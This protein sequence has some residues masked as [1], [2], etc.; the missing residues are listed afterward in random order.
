MAGQPMWAAVE[1]AGRLRDALGVALP[2]G[3]PE[4]FTEV[5]PDPL[6]DLVARWART[7]GP[8]AAADLA[9][10]Y[11]LG[12]AVVGM[13]LRR[14]AADGRVAE[15]EFL[16]SRHGTQWCD[17]GVLRMLRRRCLARLRK[18]AEPVP[19]A[20]LGRFLPAWHGIGS[21][22][23]GLGGRTRARCLRRSS[24]WPARRCPR[25][26]LRRSCCPDGCP[27]TPPRCSTSSTAAGEVVWAGAG[28]VGSGDGWLVLAP[29]ESAPLLLP[30][31]GELTMTPL[32]GAVLTALGGGGGMFFRM[33]SD[34]VAAVLDGHPADDGDLV[35]ALWDLAWAGLVTNDT[36]APLRVVTSGGAPARR[37]AAPRRATGSSLAADLGSLSR[38]RAWD[39]EACT[40]VASG[41]RFRSW[42][43]RGYGSGG[44]RGPAGRFPACSIPGLARGVAAGSPAAMPRPAVTGAGPGARPCPRGPGRPRCPAGGRCCRNGTGCQKRTAC[45]QRTAF[46]AALLAASIRERPPCGRTRSR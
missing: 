5:L 23:T 18:E 31:P 37:P 4:A 8:F 19:P 22:R 10:R 42:A 46:P 7:H 24:G 11:G 2:V 15:G 34:R 35:A 33:L 17:S 45:S 13:A 29:A 39:A 27:A 32:H 44:P 43:D 25:R 26:R 38:D 3:I 16:A 40:A 14:L 9:A 6:G 12:V 28:S 21:G 20:A 41:R 30:E 1:D 36:L